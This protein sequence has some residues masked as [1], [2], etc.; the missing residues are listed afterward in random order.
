MVRR[1]RYLSGLLVA[2]VGLPFIVSCGD[3]TTTGPAVGDLVFVATNGGACPGSTSCL[4]L[5]GH[6]RLAMFDLRNDSDMNLGPAEVGADNNI[7]MVGDPNELCD[8]VQAT[9]VGSPTAVLTPGSAAALSITIDMSLVNV[10]DC[11]VGTYRA[12]FFASVSNQIL[13][14][15]TVQFD[16]D[17]TLP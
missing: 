3:S 14:G 10:I 1:S 5:T 11:P 16:W 13:A 4:V 8:N 2:V 9:I 12:P 15:G 6:E 7:I 17:G